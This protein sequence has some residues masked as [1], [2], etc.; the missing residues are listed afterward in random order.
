VVRVIKCTRTDVS[1]SPER[2]TPHLSEPVRFRYLNR[3]SVALGDLI[4]FR[5]YLRRCHDCYV[6]RK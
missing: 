3:P 4:R 5:E 6:Q 1:R 2:L